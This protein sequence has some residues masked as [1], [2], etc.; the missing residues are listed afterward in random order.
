MTPS[1]KKLCILGLA[2]GIGN[3]L[4]T[5]SDDNKVIWRAVKLSEAGQQAIDSL[6]VKIDKSTIRR[7]TR[8]IDQ[9]CKDK[10][11]FDVAEMLSFLLLGLFDL[12][13]YCKN[14]KHLDLVQKRALWFVKLF[15]PKLDNE[16]IHAEALR[17]YEEWVK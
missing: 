10:D 2:T 3:M 9:V 5:Q 4:R 1:L 13:H 15:D 14:N 16:E 7:V 12:Q 11:I 6:P 17:R 8:K